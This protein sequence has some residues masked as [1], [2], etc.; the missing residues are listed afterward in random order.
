M[1]EPKTISPLL[2]GFTIGNPMSEHDGVQCCPAIKE[3]SDTKYIVKI[4]SV[5]ATQRQMDALLLAGAY[6]DPADAMDYYK[7]QAEDVARE[8]EL[9]RTL[10]QKEGFLPYEGWQIEPIT[11]HRL[12]Y[13]VYLISSYKR[14]LEKHL[15]RSPVTHLEAFN[16]A[17]DI[18]GALSACRKA[19]FLYVDLKPSNIFMSEQKEY[20]IG[21]LGFLSLDALHYLTLP[22][23]YRSPYTPGEFEDPMAPLNVTADTYALGMILYQLYNDHR[24]PSQEELTGENVPT[25]VNADYELAEIIMK[26]IH[27][28]PA[29]RWQDPEAL[30]QALVA[31]MQRNAVNDV[32]ITPHVPLDPEAA[33]QTAAEEPASQET[34]PDEV[35]SPAPELETIVQ[36]ESAEPEAVPENTPEGST[37]PEPQEEDSVPAE[38]N[39]ELL[40][41]HE[42]SDELSRIVAKAHDLIAHETPEGIV[43]P[44]PPDPFAFVAEDSDEIDDSGVPLEP[45]MDEPA[46]PE[47][48]NTG[49]K[50]KKQRFVSPKRKQRVRRFFL[51]LLF[52]AAMSA[53]G[54]C[55]YLYYQL[56][57][58]IPVH[59]LSIQGTEQS[60]TVTVDT[61]AD[62]SKLLVRCTDVYGNVH[63]A[64]VTNH[65]ASFG[66]LFS[67]TVYSIQLEYD[68]FHKLSG[69]TSGEFTTAATTNIVSFTAANGPEDGSFVLNFTVDGEEPK[70]WIMLCTKNGESVWHEIFTG[71]SVTIKG[72]HVGEVYTFT[73]QPH[74]SDLTIGGMTSIDCMA[75]RVLLAEDLTVTTESETQMTLSWRIPGDV[76]VESWDV[77]CYN[78]QGYDV[79][80]TVDST[81]AVIPVTRLSAGY[82]VEI[83]AA[84]MT[85]PARFSITRDPIVIDQFT[86]ENDQDPA[87]NR[88]KLSWSFTGDAPRDGWLLMYTV[89]GASEPVVVKCKEPSAEIAPRI[90]GAKY[91]FTLHSANATS[92]LN[93]TYSCVC[94][95]PEP[96]DEHGLTP[97]VITARLLQTPEEKN[98]RA[99]EVSDSAFTNTF[100]AGCGISVVL[101]TDS[102]FY[103]PG[104]ETRILY[105]YSDAHGNAIADLAQEKKVYWKNLWTAGDSKYCELNV[106]MMPDAP[107]NYL[108]NIYMDGMTV[109]QLPLTIQ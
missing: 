33:E 34:S 62:E 17:I 95:E 90:P 101:H 108:L 86:I 3:N 88:L 18:C 10:S 76:V 80:L 87:A 16:M 2:D 5:P 64:S 77:H 37:V 25:P 22:N 29:Q 31:Y 36:E 79:Q 50:K 40:Q 32:P 61:E 83:T 13:Y 24:L 70:E 35:P 8:A 28:D 56:F 71:H 84:G 38:E 67:D 52:L 96:F 93:N 92:V 26:A 58:L 9:L 14:S 72:L 63:T 73:L 81:Q 59:S 30:R 104:S 51:T 55:G 66:G 44:E 98:W 7:E 106:P 68:G 6:K 19:G 54:L 48:K 1:S 107:G 15:H 109:A 74:N 78:S 11:K 89:D 69:E 53:V 75:S 20:R 105:V 4:I 103:L 85:Q 39:A 60:L 100:P 21:D 46:E 23:K 99:E 49:K 97:D 41:P 82:T 12:G 57:Y 47:T 27:Q 45:L 102:S 91:T 65:E 43:I 42:M 94:L